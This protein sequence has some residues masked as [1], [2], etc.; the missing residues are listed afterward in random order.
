MIKI[1]N[2]LFPIWKPIYGP[3][4]TC[5]LK[6][7]ST[8]MQYVMYPPTLFLYSFSQYITCVNILKRN[9]IPIF[10]F[11]IA[12]KYTNFLGLHL[13]VQFIYF[14]MTGW[15]WNLYII[16]IHTLDTEFICVLKRTHDP[17]AWSLYNVLSYSILCNNIHITQLP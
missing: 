15:Y 10:L 11:A 7:R 8:A 12:T 2:C 3:K 14:V 4:C 16:F 9:E 1:T 6:F 5:I 13:L 17:S